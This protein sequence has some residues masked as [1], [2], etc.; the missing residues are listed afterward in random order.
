MELVSLT[1]SSVRTP[2]SPL[3]LSI[4]SHIR[5]RVLNRY[6]HKFIFIISK[7]GYLYPR[8]TTEEEFNAMVA[9]IRTYMINI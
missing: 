4:V 6:V 9:K 5:E 7:D 3:H 2:S 1:I 8:M